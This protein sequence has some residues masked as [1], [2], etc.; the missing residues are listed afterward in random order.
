MK[1]FHHFLAARIASIAAALLLIFGL[2][3]LWSADGAADASFGLYL[4]SAGAVLAVAALGAL[5]VEAQRSRSERA[6]AIEALLTMARGEELESTGS[7]ELLGA[8]SAVS[9]RFRQIFSAAES[10]STDRSPA[11]QADGQ[12]ADGVGRV[13]ERFADVHHRMAEIRLENDRMAECITELA[14]RFSAAA[15]G[16]LSNISDPTA[17]RFDEVSANYNSFVREVRNIL[18]RSGAISEQIRVQ[19][20]SLIDLTDQISRSCTIQTSQA[21]R[22]AAAS[23][24]IASRIGEIDETSNDAARIGAE[25]LRSARAGRRSTEDTVGAMQFVRRQAQE[26]SKR[27]KRL[28]ER[29]QEIAQIFALIDDL[30]DKTSLLA[31]NASLQ[32]SASGE[33]GSAFVAIADEVERLAERSRKLTAEAALLTNAINSVTKEAVSSM[34]DTVREVVVGSSLAEKAGKEL[35]SIETSARELAGKLASF[36]E[37]AKD[38]AAGSDDLSA[39]LTS[40]S[41]AAGIV[42]T[43]TKRVAESNRAVLRLSE[44]LLDAGSNFDHSQGRRPSPAISTSTE[45]H[46][47]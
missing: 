27:V 3:G 16:D 31:L 38:Q 14:A 40:I 47:N 34:D 42:G 8:I 10:I 36:S 46:I 19:S 37:C 33:A 20:V 43:V 41:E 2:L 13:I 21:E 45:A 15:R 7:G 22:A 1:D 32:A 24:R 6:E 17:R 29:S 26:T 44:E 12:E 4:A 25:F 11:A 30:S 18:A 5:M 23:A 9:E 35:G 39:A 28:G